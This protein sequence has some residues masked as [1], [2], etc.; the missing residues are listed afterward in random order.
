[1]ARYLGVSRTML[2]MVEIGQRDLPIDALKKLNV[3][4]MTQDTQNRQ[5][6]P[7]PRDTA[8]AAEL[9]IMRREIKKILRCK[10]ALA[11]RLQ[12]QLKKLC[13]TY[14]AQIALAKGLQRLQ[15]AAL[16]SDR[17]GAHELAHERHFKLLPSEVK[18]C[19]PLKHSLLRIQLQALKV[20]I[21]LLEKL[22]A[23]SV[24]KGFSIDE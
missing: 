2:S 18:A 13:E 17:N 5:T 10:K 21:S 8:S 11:S 16:K 12:M 24:S 14:N 1:M 22:L 6:E 7:S 9:A 3:L 19:N 20:E 4:A 23:T 15:R